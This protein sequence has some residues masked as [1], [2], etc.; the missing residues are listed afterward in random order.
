MAAVLA[1]IAL[2]CKIGILFPCKSGVKIND[3]VKQFLLH[4]PPV[5]FHTDLILF[6]CAVR[7]AAEGDQCGSVDRDA[8]RVCHLHQL[9]QA[10]ERLLRRNAIRFWGA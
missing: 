10:V 9:S 6:R 2:F 4:Q 5:D 1:R 3:F 8:V 7:R